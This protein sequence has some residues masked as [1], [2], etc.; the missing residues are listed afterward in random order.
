MT[1][2]ACAVLI[3]HG[4]RAAGRAPTAP[5]RLTVLRMIPVALLS[6]DR[7]AAPGPVVNAFRRAA[8]GLPRLVV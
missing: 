1:R 4:G 6:L 2:P 5:A 3:L 7:P 8:A